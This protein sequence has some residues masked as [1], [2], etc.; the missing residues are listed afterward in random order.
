MAI[1]APET[2][3]G[4]TGLAQRVQCCREEQLLDTVELSPEALSAK[5]AVSEQVQ[6]FQSQMWQLSRKVPDEKQAELMEAVAESMKEAAKQVCA[7]S[8]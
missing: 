1:P 4:H 7:E 3:A 5:Q 6:Q 2:W 8:L